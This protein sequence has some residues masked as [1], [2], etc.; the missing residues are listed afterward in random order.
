[1]A[2]GDRNWA[3]GV[4][5]RLAFIESRLFWDGSVKRPDII[6]AFEIAVTQASKDLA[7]YQAQAPENLRYDGARKCYVPTPQ[8]R[9]RFI[10]LDGEAYLRGLPNPEAV[11]GEREAR[12]LMGERLPA[13]SRRID[14]LSLRQVAWALRDGLSLEIEYLSS[15]A[16][17]LGPAW[18][19]VSPHAFAHNGWRWYVRAYCHR[20]ERFV[21]FVVSR[22]RAA[23]DPGPA[24]RGGQEDDAWRTLFAVVLAP[25]PRLSPPLQAMVADDFDMAGGEAIVR[26]RKAMLRD[27]S[28]HHR[29]DLADRT[30]D[31]RE[32]PVVA[33]N[34]AELEAAIAEAGPP[35]LGGV[36]PLRQKR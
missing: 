6:A 10:Q 4:E 27:F 13:P 14:P 7:L 36:I 25:N 21:D 20:E 24:G 33:R 22:I 32:V 8:F 30:D 23:R 35:E 9:P 12:R 15:S 3:W 18:R 2:V 11:D 26:V 17:Q 29:L 31:P 34:R 19:R 28:K 1:M 16:D 5:Q